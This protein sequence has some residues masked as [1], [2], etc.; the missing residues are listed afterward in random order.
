[1]LPYIGDLLIA[2]VRARHLVDMFHKLRT[3]P[4][5]KLAPRSI[6][7]IYSVVSAMFRDAKLADL[8]EQSPSVLD[9]RHLGPL[10]DR[11][12]E[13]R[14]IAVFT[15]EEA[16]TIISDTRIPPDREMAYA[17]EL[18]AGVRPG[19]ASALRFRHYDPT[20]RPLGKLL[21]AKSYSTRVGEKTTKT[22]AV[23]HVPVHPT[24]AA[25]LAEWKLGGW[26]AMMGRAPT[27][28]DLIVPL[29]P[30]AA[31]RRTKRKGEPFRTTYYSGKCWREDDLPA[32]GWRHR[33]HYDMRATF[34]T[35]AIDD[36][37]DPDVLE[38]RVTHTR[39]SR[40]A[41]DGYN[42]GLQWE[43]TCAEVL[44]LRIARGVRS[45]AAEQPI[46]AGSGGDSLHSLQSS[47][48]ARIKM[49]N[50]ASLGVP[51]REW[52]AFYRHFHPLA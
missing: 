17:I 40:N 16:E 6:Y 37:A 22:D 23:K 10:I 7:N 15:H 50:L 49:E 24:L 18:L 26:A 21:V 5:I 45:S 19:E 34:I 25:M 4:N 13:W 51:H 31:E 14:S 39:K 35:L 44:K 27:P 30:D 47:Q 52:L 42:R 8:I 1:V 38:T 36:G 12:P 11:D 2:E 33:R 41:F 48:V 20:V 28:D 29:P 9:E 32:L 43:R 46:A 3:D